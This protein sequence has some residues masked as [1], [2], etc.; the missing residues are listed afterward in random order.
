MS[1]RGGFGD[2]VQLAVNDT[3]L[4]RSD[5]FAMSW[6]G[7]SNLPK[8]EI[9]PL[10]DIVD[11]GKAAWKRV[12]CGDGAQLYPSLDDDTDRVLWSETRGTTDVVTR[13]SAAGTCA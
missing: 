1:L 13:A 9:A 8:L 6:G 3:S 5:S 12:S 11:D 4:V 10:A 2:Y 7:P